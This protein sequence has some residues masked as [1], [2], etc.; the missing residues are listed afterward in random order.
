MSLQDP[1]FC[2]RMFD[3]FSVYPGPILFDRF[4][5]GI[6]VALGFGDVEEDWGERNFLKPLAKIPLDAATIRN[7]VIFQQRNKLLMD[8]RRIQWLRKAWSSAS[9]SA[10][11]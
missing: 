10:R 7:A 1:G 6:F 2:T 3:L 9:A 4:W 11:N 8:Q 5:L